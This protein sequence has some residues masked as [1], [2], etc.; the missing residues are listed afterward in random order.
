MLRVLIPDPSNLLKLDTK[1]PNPLSRVDA[2]YTT[3]VL[4]LSHTDKVIMAVASRR[5]SA[6]SVL[7]AEAQVRA[8]NSHNDDQRA[9]DFRIGVQREIV[10]IVISP[11][12]DAISLPC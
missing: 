11:E 3:N 12:F 10:R 9:R 2:K 5:K 1:A 6:Q 4:F 8:T 7:R